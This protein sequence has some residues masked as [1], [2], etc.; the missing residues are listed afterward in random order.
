MSSSTFGGSSI[1][2]PRVIDNAAQFAAAVVAT[3]ENDSVRSCGYPE[4]TLIDPMK[5]S[6][7]VENR[8]SYNR[9]WLLPK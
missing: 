5:G 3:S 4:M 7:H 1:A 6:F 9:H 8:L 2:L